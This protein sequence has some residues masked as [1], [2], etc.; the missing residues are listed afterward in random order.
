MYRKMNIQKN[1]LTEHILKAIEE[2]DIQHYLLNAR[3]EKTE[4]LFFVKKECT[5]RRNKLTEKCD[6]TIYHDFEAN[7]KQ[8]RGSSSFIADINMD[9]DELNKKIRTAY[10]SAAS[11]KNP[12]YQ[13]PASSER[14]AVPEPETLP[15][16]MIPRYHAQD[17]AN[18]IFEEDRDTAAFI[19]SLEIFITQCSVHIIN[20]NGINVS[21]EDIT[22]SGE[23][24]VQSKTPQDV[25]L[26]YDFQ[27]SSSDQ[28][29]EKSLRA[30]I[31]SSLDAIKV[32]AHAIPLSELKKQRGTEQLPYKNLILEG[33]SVY[34]L[35]AY[36]LRRLDASMIYP[37]YSNYRLGDS[38]VRNA[39][40]DIPS[41]KLTITVTPKVPYSS[42]GIRLSGRCLIQDN[43]I[44]LI[45][46][47]ARFS[48]YLGIP[49][50]GEYDSYRLQCGTTP[51]AAMQCQPYLK[52]VNFSDF[53]M[54]ELTGQ[55]GGEYRLAY[56]FDGKETI[57]V[58]NGSI[59]GNINDYISHITLSS[60]NQ[61]FYYF[62][63]PLAV[64]FS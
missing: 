30:S 19:N 2:N 4:E 12:Y 27:Y 1:R 32:R 59:S 33:K 58:T 61:S 44:R 63:G 23:Y 31:C 39:G 6:V 45:T 40:H 22:Y 11:V 8:Y 16:D 43:I 60:E 5:L 46:G 42:E 54:D 21:Y 37:K 15:A 29:I 52:I 17:I 18:I 64:A 7:G 24:V 53:Q 50:T 62:D 26:Y 36:Y 55:F 48:S 13:L 20:S 51:L 57:G 47:N 49:A 35:I 25:E 10:H 3:L 34:E 56:Y 41:D 9:G 14:F 28:E 38:I